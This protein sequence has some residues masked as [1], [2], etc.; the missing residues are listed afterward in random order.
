MPLDS[1]VAVRLDRL[2]A[3]AHKLAKDGKPQEARA[4]YKAITQEHP[5]LLAGWLNLGA[6]EDEISRAEAGK[7]GGKD[8]FAQA[9]KIR[10]VPSVVNDLANIF[11]RNER[12]WY[13]AERFY[14]EAVIRHGMKDAAE[15]LAICLLTNAIYKESPEG[16][17]EAWQW[18]E[19][20][21]MNK[22]R[23]HEMVW[24]GEP[25]AGKRI[26]IRLEQG[27]GDHMFGLRFVKQAKEEG[28]TTL[29]MAP[30]NS[31]RLC[32]SQPY[33]DQV[34]DDREP[35]EIEADYVTMLMSMP[36]YMLKDSMPRAEPKYLV[37]NAEPVKS[38]KKRIGLAWSGSMDK[39]YQA[40]RNVPLGLLGRLVADHPEYEFVSLQK[41]PHANDVPEL[42]MNRDEIE[43]CKDL[44]D[45]A[46][47]I[48]SCDLVISPDTVIPHLSAAL[49]V[50]TFVLA[51][52]IACWVWGVEGHNP[53]WYEAAMIFRQPSFGDWSSVIE[54]VSQELA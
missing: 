1:Q 40:W 3:H 21:T 20:R 9:L 8:A 34:F 19:W 7:F 13:E 39:G 29:V 30:P 49:G 32:A 43:G 46:R 48:E 16:W 42:E 11:L 14:K 15:N 23:D 25:L 47:L 50:K 6:I 2:L 53:N 27:L 22:C 33:V 24:R 31:L 5:G 52:W 51:R 17:R 12:R 44:L 28:A 37:T 35:H 41:G 26:I 54:Q 36:G 45:T 4:I 18:Y 38:E 10:I